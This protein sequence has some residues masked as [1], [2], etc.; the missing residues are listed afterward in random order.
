MD[1]LDRNFSSPVQLALLGILLKAVEHGKSVSF[2]LGAMDDEYTRSWMFQHPDIRG[3]LLGG[4]A[5]SNCAAYQR[6]FESLGLEAPDIVKTGKI[7]NKGITVTTLDCVYLLSERNVRG[8][9]T[10]VNKRNPS[11]SQRVKLISLR[12]GYPMKVE[13]KGRQLS[14]SAVIFIE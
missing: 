9:C 12:L 5:E 10:I 2:V 3:D 13:I 4:A 7:P 8:V 6:L 1:F 14:T 11:P